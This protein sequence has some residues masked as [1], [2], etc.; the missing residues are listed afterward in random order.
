MLS[1]NSFVSLP[2]PF[3]TVNFT[4]NVPNSVGLPEIFPFVLNFRPLGRPSALHVR[5]F[6]PLALRVM[7]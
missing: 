2:A 6:V 3:E 5:G 1:F 7:L 4:V